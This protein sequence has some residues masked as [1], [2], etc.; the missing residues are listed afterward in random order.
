VTQTPLDLLLTSWRRSLRARN[1]APRT[2]QSY[3]EAVDQFA[4]HAGV[5]DPTKVT[6]DM[7][8]GWLAHVVETKSPATAANRYRSLRVFFTWLEDEE[9][10]DRSPM[11]RMKAPT[12]PETPVAT[13]T[14]DTVRALLDTCKGR[15][16]ADRRD[17]AIFM[18]LYDCGVRRSE[19]AGLTVA[20]VDSDQDVLWVVG[21]G[22]R[23]RGAPFGNATGQ[24]LDRYLRARA[25]H[26]L[27]GRE[28]LWLGSRGP[29]TS[30]GVRQMIERRAAQAGV[31]HLHAH[32]FRHGF[33]HAFRAAGGGDDDLMRL[34]GWRSREML[35]KYGR[36]VADERARDAHRRLSPGDRL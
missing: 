35:S 36:S 3:T 6:P 26:E 28:E 23:R 4:A 1:R 2:I 18:V 33:A 22:S 31:G 8:A 34:A 29:L 7:I 30:D 20:D 27:A 12:V 10:I 11:A 13:V 17:R 21:K 9:E 19:L 32:M 14:A 15:D 24:A 5:D 25:R 16:F